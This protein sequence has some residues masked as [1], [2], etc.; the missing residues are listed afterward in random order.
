[1][2]DPVGSKDLGWVL[3]FLLCSENLALAKGL[4]ASIT[5]QDFTTLS[6]H[7]SL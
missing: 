2:V 5:V 7:Q 3:L 4:D 6:H 1:M